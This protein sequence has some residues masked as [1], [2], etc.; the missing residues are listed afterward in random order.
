[1]GKSPEKKKKK[2]GGVG[3]EEKEN[4][5][6]KSAVKKSPGWRIRGGKRREGLE[7]TREKPARA[8]NVPDRGRGFASP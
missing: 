1:V 3:K 6:K 8:P 7:G 2:K 4:V 5:Q